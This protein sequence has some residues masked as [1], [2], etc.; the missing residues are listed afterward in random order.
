MLVYST[1]IPILPF[2]VA[3]LDG[4]SLLTGTL[5]AVYALGIVVSAPLFGYCADR[6]RNKRA[7]MVGGLAALLLAV[8]AMAFGTSFWLWVVA[9]LLQ[10]VSAGAIWSLGLA[11]V[12]DAYHDAP[13]GF[14]QAMSVIMVGYT[15]G[16]VTGP[17][18]GGA[19]YAVSHTAPFYFCA[20]VVLVDLVLRLIVV[21][22]HRAD[23]VGDDE[24]MEE[25]FI[26]VVRS[27]SDGAAPAAAVGATETVTAA[28]RRAAQRGGERARPVGFVEMLKSKPLLLVLGMAVVNGFLLGSFEPTLPTFLSTTYSLT[29]GQVGLAFFALVLPPIFWSP[30]AGYVAERYGARPLIPIAMTLTVG[31]EV[32]PGITVGGG[33]PALWWTLTALAVVASTIACALAP[34]VPEIAANVPRDA[35][36]KAYS[37]FNVAWS[38]GTAFGPTLGSAVFQ[39]AGW[40]WQCVFCA[41]FA[42]VCLPLAYLY[43]PPERR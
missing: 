12:A 5:L 8:L 43:R 42:A 1:I 27:S 40:F 25:V 26:V 21:E 41:S 37:L 35:Y 13:A 19:L 20:A 9:R 28:T 38:L 31:A 4:S 33:R 34:L 17:P 2:I 6:W 14:A 39:Y 32:L 15:V 22:P 24:G 36:A 16:T 30:V 23:D 7:P 18:I 3:D 11:L 29:T 10:G